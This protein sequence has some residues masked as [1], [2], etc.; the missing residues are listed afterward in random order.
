MEGRKAC[1]VDGCGRVARSPKA[2][3]CEAHYYRLRRNGTL[4]LKPPK[5]EYIHAG[6]YRLVR[7]EG[8]PLCTSGGGALVY[9][10]RRV[11]YDARGSGPFACHVCGAPVTWADLHIDHLNDR[12]DDNR[13]DNLAPAC[14]TCNQ[15][16]GRDAM[17]RAMRERHGVWLEHAGERMTLGQWA[18][19]LG[20]SRAALGFRLRKGWS[21]ARALTEARGPTGPRRMVG[22]F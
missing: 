11:F 18:E 2:A 17:V 19:R 20:I 1:D 7:A 12:K 6:G 22:G 15:A 8:H 3:Y 9:E 5:A 14:P 16:R 13:L 10:H 4:T 21:L